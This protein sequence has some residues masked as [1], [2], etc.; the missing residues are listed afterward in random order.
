M[1]PFRFAIEMVNRGWILRN[2]IIWHKRNCMPS[3]VKD[4]FTVD[5]EYLFFFVKNKKYWFETQY[6]PQL[7]TRQAGTQNQI[8]KGKNE[9]GVK[10]WE[11]REL[12]SEGRSNYPKELWAEM[13]KEL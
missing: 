12:S 4:R 7:K 13:G 9:D 3:S 8:H 5:Y 2:T 6:E 1:I 11:R 10:G